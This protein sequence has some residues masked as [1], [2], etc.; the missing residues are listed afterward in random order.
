MTSSET[1]ARLKVPREVLLD[2]ARFYDGLGCVVTGRPL[3]KASL[4]HLDGD[5]TF[6]EFPNLLPLTLDL[7]NGLRRLGHALDD[8]RPE[9]RVNRL[10]E[11]AEA[12]FKDGRVPQAY[13]CMR[14][15]H[16]L[17]AH[18]SKPTERDLDGEFQLAAHCLYYLR[19]AIGAS[20]LELVY[21]NML[22]LLHRE[23]K[24][25]LESHKVIP[26]FGAFCLLIEFGSWLNELGWSERGLS[27]LRSARERLR[28]FQRHLRPVDVSRFQRQLANA[29]IQM[30]QCRTE[31]EAALQMSVD[32]GDASDNNRFALFNTRLNLHISNQQMKEALATLKERFDYF[33]KQTDFFF[34]PLTAMGPTIQTS[35]AYIALSLLCESQV[36]RSQRHRKRLEDRLEALRLQERRYGVGTLLNRFDGLDTAADQTMRNLP[37]M[38]A[39]LDGRLFPV[40]PK[41]VADSISDIAAML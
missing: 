22:C 19:R 20:R 41:H 17:S 12:H 31:L 36:V 11:T 2:V 7:H 30:G 15:A 33:E 6:S 40:L 8:L 26:P 38:Q 29:L 27:L 10:K 9:L 4:H 35:L 23:L 34:G 18:F 37:A 5:N 16:A 25:T 39:F 1:K 3:T 28:G 32:S 14:L 21:S 13:G 24:Q